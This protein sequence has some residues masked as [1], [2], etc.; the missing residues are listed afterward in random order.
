MPW[1]G[2]VEEVETCKRR[3]G[4]AVMKRALD[5]KYGKEPVHVLLSL[6]LLE[7]WDTRLGIAVRSRIVPY[8]CFTATIA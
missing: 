5:P 3:V 4:E 6:K 2:E 8:M 7:L 1:L